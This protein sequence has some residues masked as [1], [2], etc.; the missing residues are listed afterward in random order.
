MKTWKL[1]SGILSIVMFVFVSF[2]SCAA[3]VS[4]S[5]EANGEVGG[6]AG[7]I[8]AILLLAGGIVSIASRRG[9]K[10]GNIALIVLFGLGALFGFT[11]AGSYKDLN[12]WAA[13][14]LICVILAIISLVKGK[15]VQ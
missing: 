7:V 4:N 8:V 1:V 3:G 2:Q 6:S 10:G 15:K 5:L 9:S 11:M 12:I 13:W 14:C